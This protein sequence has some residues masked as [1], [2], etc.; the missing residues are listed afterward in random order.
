MLEDRVGC[1]SFQ[2]GRYGKLRQTVL[3][4]PL[5]DSFSRPLGQWK[6]VSSWCSNVH[7]SADT[8]ST[9]RR[10]ASMSWTR[11]LISMLRPTGLL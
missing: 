7:P 10:I 6:N 4:N 9:R 11:D 1:Q 3:V 2:F 5:V 8:S